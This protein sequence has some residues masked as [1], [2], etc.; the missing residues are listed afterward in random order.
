MCGY[1][2]GTGAF[3]RAAGGL[4]EAAEWLIVLSGIF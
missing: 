2:L 1:S 4:S 3:S